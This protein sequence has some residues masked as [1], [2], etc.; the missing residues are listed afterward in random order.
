VKIVNKIRTVALSTLVLLTAASPMRGNVATVDPRINS[1]SCILSS[2][3]WVN[4]PL[5]I[6][7]GSFRVSFDATPSGSEI[8]AV[9]GLSSGPASSFTNLAAIVRFNASGAID[10]RN[11]STYT[12]ASHIRYSA[13]IRYHFILDVNVATH[14]YSAS[15]MIGSR[16]T[17]IGTN[18]AFRSEQASVTKLAYLGVMTDP[19]THTVCNVA[20]SNTAVRPSITAQPSSRTVT[21]GQSASFSIATTGTAPLTYQWKRNGVAITGANSSNYSTAVTTS[22]DNGAQFTAVVSNSAGTATSNVALLTVKAAV[23]VPSIS[24]QPVSQSLTAGQSATFSVVATG[25]GPL[26]Y[27]WSRNGSPISGAISASYTTA[28]TRV[29][30]N[31]ALFN[32]RVSNTAGGATSSTATLSVKASVIAPTIT[33]QPLAQSVTAGQAATFSVATTGTAPMTYQWSRNG[34]PIVGANSSSYTT[35]LTTSSDDGAQFR[36]FVS[37]SAGNATSIPARLAVKA[38]GPPCLLSSPT[39]TGSPLT[40][41]QTSSFR[42]QFDITPAILNMDAVTGLSSNPAAVYQ[43]LAAA[44]RFNRAGMIDARNGGGYAAASAIAYTGG[45]PYHFTLDIDISTHTYDAYVMIG[46]VQTLIGSHFAFRNEQAAATSLGY[47][48]AH[49]ETGSSTI[50]NAVITAPAAIAPSI[51]TQPISRSVGAGQSATFSVVASGTATLTYQ[52]KK[53]G[54]LVSGATS[55]SYTTPVATAPDN[56]AQFTVVVSNAAG[57]ATSNP[58]S[59]TVSAAATLLLNPSPHSLNFGSVNV[60]SSSARNVTLTNAGNANVTISQV[61]VGGAGFNATGAS[62]LILVPGQSTTLTSTFAPSASGPATGNITVSSNASNS[63]ASLS[64]SG[65]GVAAAAHSVSLVWTGAVSGV[66]GYHAYSSTTPGGPFVRMT[67]S[68]LA[69]PSY[70]DSS[71][72]SGRTYYYAVTAVNSSNQESAYSSVVTAIIP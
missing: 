65:T 16:Q 33:M 53:N 60:A 57:S 50:C 36:V 49:A 38:G 10:A 14:R 66:T 6:E 47:L 64:L 9:T 48:N 54:S 44:V 72:Q 4:V 40:Q 70:T 27:Q 29:S 31:G 43:D 46:S 45:S 24:V 35:A 28:V 15:V 68:P 55:A 23:M 18:L 58:A 26:T 59:L 62:G 61:L 13:G 7:S 20:L 8:D 71:V 37:N 32:V 2:G 3:S 63:P 12:A 11:G 69:N 56:G 51:T 19:G 17:L 21:A 41:I 39:W 22:A 1:R 25:T 34:S 67:S 42:I 30:D 5:Q 52:W